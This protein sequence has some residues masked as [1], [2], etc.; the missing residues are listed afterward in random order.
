MSLVS[1]ASGQ[2]RFSIMAE[3]TDALVD[4]DAYFAGNWGVSLEM[5]LLVGG[6]QCV[7]YE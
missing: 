1:I 2:Y 5:V 3:E 6:I 4:L 7:K